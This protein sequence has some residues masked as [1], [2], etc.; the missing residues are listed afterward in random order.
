M[1]ED[2]AIRSSLEDIKSRVEYELECG[3][4]VLRM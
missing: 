1:S 2:S 3:E 4:S